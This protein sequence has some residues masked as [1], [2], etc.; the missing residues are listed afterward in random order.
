MDGMHTRA[1]EVALN[2]EARAVPEG[3]SVADMLA[4]LSLP[5]GKI[6]VERNE[7]IVPRSRYGETLLAPG[8]RLEIVHFIGGG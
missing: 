4:A 5:P 6:A 2:G 8:D 1:I 3:S 7:A